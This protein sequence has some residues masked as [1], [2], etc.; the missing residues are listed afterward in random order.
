[1]ALENAR[2]D[3]M[4]RGLDAVRSTALLCDRFREVR[5]LTPRA[6]ALL[7]RG[8]VLKLEQKRLATA[9]ARDIV[10]IDGLIGDTLA[11]D[12]D[13]VRPITLKRAGSEERVLIEAAPIPADETFAFGDCALLL[14]HERGV[15]EE[16][17]MTLARALY[18]L[19]TSESAVAV[20]VSLG[21]S[22][23]QIARRRHVSLGTVRCQ[24]RNIFAKTRASSLVELS[25]LLA[26]LR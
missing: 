23:A 15:E 17:L 25:A 11:G 20:Q 12:R 1:M 2:L 10:L 22:P 6:E 18:G 26:G 7:S 4:V 9:D 8:D 16:R 19:S 14:V 24:V 21:R 3:L 5:A 13:G